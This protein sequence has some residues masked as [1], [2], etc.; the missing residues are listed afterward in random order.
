MIFNGSE[1]P[2]KSRTNFDGTTKFFDN[3][4]HLN[5]Y[6]QMPDEPSTNKYFCRDL[7]KAA[8]ESL[9]LPLEDATP[10]E[11]VA[12]KKKTAHKAID[13]ATEGPETKQQSPLAA[14][15]DVAMSPTTP[16]A[17]TAVTTTGQAGEI[18]VTPEK[19]AAKKIAPA[20]L[21]T[22]SAEGPNSESGKAPISD[23]PKS[24]GATKKGAYVPRLPAVVQALAMAPPA[25][26]S[27][28]RAEAK[29]EAQKTVAGL[30]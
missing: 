23:C 14:I 7:I 2:I 18:I 1:F 26:P 20:P 11:P 4:D 6:V 30:K 17:A 5:T 22:I 3:W 9:V 28:K 10:V 24:T 25:T 19:A 15:Q 13:D 16:Q 21:N 29:I 12:K 27:T 8:M